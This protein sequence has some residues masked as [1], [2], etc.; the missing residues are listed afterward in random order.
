[1]FLLVTPFI[2][3][4]CFLSRIAMMT[5]TVRDV[6]MMTTMTTITVPAISAALMAFLGLRIG[7]LI[8]SLVVGTRSSV[9]VLSESAAGSV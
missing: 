9:P 2:V 6:I 4:P 5:T 7:S 3:F 1:M 8:V